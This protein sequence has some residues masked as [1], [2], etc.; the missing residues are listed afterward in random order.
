MKNYDLI[1]SVEYRYLIYLCG[2]LEQVHNSF[3]DLVSDRDVKLSLILKVDFSLAYDSVLDTIC[4]IEQ[5]ING[6]DVYSLVIA[7]LEAI[8]RIIENL[9][10]Y[11]DYFRSRSNSE[12]L[13]DSSGFP[14]VKSFLKT[15]VIF[16]PEL[17]F[18]TFVTKC[19]KTTG[20]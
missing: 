8:G 14:I 15:N 9:V 11:Y 10:D 3:L 13:E 4:N 1:T 20:F 12:V 19:K 7:E 6:L 18:N 2:E 17:C 16:C 5:Q